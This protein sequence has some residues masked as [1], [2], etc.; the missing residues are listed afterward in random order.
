MASTALSKAAE[1]RFQL[2]DFELQSG[3]VL[4]DAFLGYA[5]HGTLNDTRDNVI[6]YPTWYTGHHSDTEPYIGPG[7]A[8]DPE[9][10]SMAAENCTDMAVENYTLL[11]AKRGQ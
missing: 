3:T 2:G 7:K 5:T 10:L 11:D 4:P 6:V 9:R 1:G 8:L